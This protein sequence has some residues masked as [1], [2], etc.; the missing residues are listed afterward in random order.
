M[1]RNYWSD[2]YP[3]KF[4]VLKTSIYALKAS[5]LGQILV[6]KYQIF[7]KFQG[8]NI[9]LFN[10]RLTHSASELSGFTCTSSLTMNEKFQYRTRRPRAVLKNFEFIV[11]ERV[12]VNPD[13]SRAKSVL[14]FLLFKLNTLQTEIVKL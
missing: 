1:S 10:Y 2:T 3:F 5:L 8:I 4:D 6:Y 7:R 12:Q 9:L 11:C 13:N 14:T